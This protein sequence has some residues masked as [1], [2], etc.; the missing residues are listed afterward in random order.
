MKLM[1]ADAMSYVLDSSIDSDS[2]KHT[3]DTQVNKL[4]NIVWIDDV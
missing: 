4:K 3:V 1:G 2:N